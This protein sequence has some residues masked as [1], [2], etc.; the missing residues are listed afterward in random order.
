MNYWFG[1]F[2]N[3]AKCRIGH[4]RVAVFQ[5]FTFRRYHQVSFLV[6]STMGTPFLHRRCLQSEIS[7][8]DSFRI[9]LGEIRVKWMLPI[10]L[11]TSS[12]TDILC[13]LRDF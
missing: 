8:A 5:V 11:V 6:P 13:T 10:T 4:A 12:V 2:L 7:T 9:S 3:V 1:E